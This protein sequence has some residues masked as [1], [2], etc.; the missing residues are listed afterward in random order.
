MVIFNPNIRWK[1][2]YDKK[3]AICEKEEKMLGNQGF[4]KRER[5]AWE[6]YVLHVGNK[7]EKDPQDCLIL[8]AQR[9]ILVLERRLQNSKKLCSLLQKKEDSLL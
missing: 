7:K 3:I 6:E 5:D 9:H 4:S 2:K 8:L 1:D